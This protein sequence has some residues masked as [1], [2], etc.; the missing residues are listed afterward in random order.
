MKIV[1]MRNKEILGGRNK[2]GLGADDPDPLPLFL[3]NHLHFVH[4]A[5]S[6]IRS[7][8]LRPK[9]V[10]ISMKDPSKLVIICRKYL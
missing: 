6:L 1:K 3:S 2:R 8:G 10:F 9:T 7:C 4:S 5:T